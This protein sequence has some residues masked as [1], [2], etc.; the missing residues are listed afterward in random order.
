MNFFYRKNYKGNFMTDYTFELNL[1]GFK[2]GDELEDHLKNEEIKRQK[3]LIEE[4]LKNKCRYCGH[5]P[6]V[7]KFGTC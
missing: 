5:T 6:I 7:N 3:E 4:R 1:K 2:W